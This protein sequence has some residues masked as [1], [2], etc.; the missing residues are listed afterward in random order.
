M[1]TLFFHSC[2]YLPKPETEI[3]LPLHHFL[4]G[5]LILGTKAD[6]LHCLEKETTRPVSAPVVSVKFSDGAPIVQMLNLGTTKTFQDNAD[7]VFT[8]YVSSP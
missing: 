1:T 2:I 5:K 6:I 4:G 7:M 8:P 3:K